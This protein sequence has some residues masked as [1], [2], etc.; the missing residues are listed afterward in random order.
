MNSTRHQVGWMVVL[1]SIVVLA[2]C[3][4]PPAPPP[5]TGD[6][7]AG[8]PAPSRP[9]VIVSEADIEARRLALARTGNAVD[10]NAVG[11]FMDVFRARVRR[12]LADTGIAIDYR[13]QSILV[14]FPNRIGFE[15][16]SAQLTE[17][18][19]GLVDRLA[20]ILNEY[21]ATLIVIS[22]HTDNVG[23]PDFNRR[24]SEARARSVA[25]HLAGSGIADARLLIQGFGSARPVA[26]N[27]SETGRASNRRV[28]LMLRLVVRQPLSDPAPSETV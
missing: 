22:G 8:Q 16:G 10:Q 14:T 18:A 21:R 27:S 20:A 3:A 6:T 23:D 1:L 4:T 24:L 26:D 7:S 19:A 25:E 15:S 5:P 9:A 17:E 11:Y 12:D 13:D 28:E 2:G